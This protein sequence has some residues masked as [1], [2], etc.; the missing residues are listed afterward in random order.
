MQLTAQSSWEYFA[1][2]QTVQDLKV[3]GDTVWIAN[4]LGLHLLDKTTGKS[5]MLNSVNSEIRGTHVLEILPAGNEVWMSMRTGGLLKYDRREADWSQYYTGM[6][7]DLDTIH[8]ARNLIVSNDG[9]V[10]F[11]MAWDGRFSLF[12]FDGE[13]VVD[14]NQLFSDIPRNVTAH[15]NKYIYFEID[16][17]LQVLDLETL[18][19]DIIEVI[20]D[21][22]SEIFHLM[23][24]HDELI[25]LVEIK[26]KNHFYKYDGVWTRLGSSREGYSGLVGR[27]ETELW[28]NLGNRNPHY[29]SLSDSGVEHYTLEDLGMDFIESDV[30]AVIFDEDKEGGL[31]FYVI[32]WSSDSDF[33]FRSL[34]GEVEAF[35]ITL[36]PLGSFSNY[37][38]S[39]A[40]FDCEGNLLNTISRGYHLFN[41]DSSSLHGALS[42]VVA[43]AVHPHTCQYYILQTGSSF[44]TSIEKAI[45]VY[46]DH[47]LVDTIEV[48]FSFNPGFGAMKFSSD[49][50]LFVGSNGLHILDEDG[51][52]YE[53]EPFWNEWNQLNYVTEIQEAPNGDM[54]FGTSHSFMIYDGENWEVFDQHNSPVGEKPI[55]N[56]EYDSQG[57]VFMTHMGWLHKYDGTSWERTYVLDPYTDGI[58]AMWIDDE[59][60]VWLGTLRSGLRLWDGENMTQVDI[61]NSSIPENYV[62]EL[63]EHPDTKELWMI[64]DYGI[65]ILNRDEIL[66]CDKVSG[67]VFLDLNENMQLDLGEEG[68]IGHQVRASSL[69]QISVTDENGLFSFCAEEGDSLL[70]EV[71]SSGDYEFTTPSSISTVHYTNSPEDLNFGLWKEP[72]VDDLEVVMNVSK[73]ECSTDAAI[74]ITLDN[75][76]DQVL[77]GTVTLELPPELAYRFSTPAS[78]L[79]GKHYAEWNFT[80]IDQKEKREFLVTVLCLDL[81]AFT[82][83][84]GNSNDVTLPLQLSVTTQNE[85]VNLQYDEPYV[86]SDNAVTKTVTS[87]GPSVN[88]YSL[89]DDGLEYTIGFRNASYTINRQVIIV[90]TIDQQM[91]I[92]T[93][94]LVSSSHKVLTH[95]DEPNII[96][97]RFDDVKLFP[98][99]SAYSHGFVKFRIWPKEGLPDP[100]VINNVAQVYFDFGRPVSTNTTSNVLLGGLPPSKTIDD[101]TENNL[102]I[103]PNPTNS[104]FFLEHDFIGEFEEV[105]LRD[106]YGREVP[107][108]RAGDN[109]FIP[110]GITAGL[111]FVE[112]FYNGERI[113]EQIVIE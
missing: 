44:E 43:I 23:A 13:T 109:H 14:H 105:S 37:Y 86:C 63:W 39:Y 73:L 80:D 60:V 18:T 83:M 84:N 41:K 40:P 4:N 50:T 30:V 98:G 96:T 75:K 17:V 38:S 100:T 70:L 56:H 99:S 47:Q 101:T 108:T 107:L 95:I 2:N 48:D 42:K 79:S 72:E 36:S 12:S 7:G 9:T 94:E 28:L 11:D 106:I 22:E 76:S 111:Y 61:M 113:L 58:S 8:R 27:G 1:K 82:V 71:R 33:I 77:S 26:D 53:D 89:L 46:D 52:R 5:V 110:V 66:S 24:F 49:G 88:Q 112:V 20:P 16:D 35:D 87:L 104:G 59:D 93:F 31:W 81:E 57:N 78:D 45:Y 64:M 10:W 54:S 25:A 51:W 102:W 97:F 15:G 62:T 3:I 69:S 68:L 85:E 92:S 19:I 74:W 34:D 6:E 91:D 29:L 21:E 90:D 65:A 67:K 32:D 55:Y 103:Y